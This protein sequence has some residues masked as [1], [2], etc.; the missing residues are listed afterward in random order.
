MRGW[1]AA[2]V[3]CLAAMAASCAAP[4]AAPIDLIAALPSAERR[5]GGNVDDAVRTTPMQFGADHEPVLLL[6]APARVIWTVK[7]PARS[8]LSASASMAAGEDGRP[9]P[10]VTLRL[11]LSDDRHYDG[12]L[13]MPIAPDREWRPVTLDLGRYSGWQWSLFYRPSKITWKLILNVD[14]TPGG[15]LALRGLSIR[16]SR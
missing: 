13:S 10:G 15:T 6:R 16:P 7:F 2:G 9:G 3:S 11:G 14:A 5:A 1:V 12:L 8:A 4:P